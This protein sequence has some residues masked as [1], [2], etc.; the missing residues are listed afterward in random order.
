MTNSLSLAIIYKKTSKG[1]KNAMKKLVSILLCVAMLCAVCVTAFAEGEP[2]TSA[3]VSVGTAEGAKGEK[4]S[5]PLSVKDNS[6]MASLTA[7]I[8]YDAAVLSITDDDITPAGILD[9]AVDTADSTKVIYQVNTAEA[10]KVYISFI[11]SENVTGD[12]ILFNVAFTIKTDAAAGDSEVTLVV[13]E[14]ANADAAIYTGY[15]AENGAVKVGESTL[16]YGDVNN[17]GKVNS[18][19]A[20]MVLQSVVGIVTL[21]ERAAKV[22]N[23]NSDNKID[24]Q[25]ALGILQYIVNIRSELPYKD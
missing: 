21:D 5:L 19:D 4:V 6:G 20:L 13:D 10:G 2:T 9:G 11:K 16:M 3:V 17:D 22:A 12:G 15:T 1:R 8:S 24:T 7:V 14:M 18:E 23:V 25:D